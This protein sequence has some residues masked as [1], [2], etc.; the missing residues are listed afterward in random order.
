MAGGLLEDAPRYTHLCALKSLADS[1]LEWGV[2]TRAHT[3]THPGIDTRALVTLLT[4]EPA[5]RLSLFTLRTV[6]TD[7]ESPG[8]RWHLPAWGVQEVTT[9]F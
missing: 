8:L 4:I 6:G 7:K 3:H 2:Y 1:R 9:V 5:L